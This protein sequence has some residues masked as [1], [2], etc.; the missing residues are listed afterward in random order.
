MWRLKRTNTCGQLSAADAAK[1]VRL[2]GWVANRR[3]HGELIFIDLRDRY[4]I[5]QIVFNPE[6]GAELMAR[7]HTLRPEFVC[8]VSGEVRKRP[9]GMRNK[10]IPTGEIEVLVK[11]LEILSPAKTPPFPIA[12]DVEVSPELRMKHRYLDLRREPMTRTLI[13]RH[14]LFQAFRRYFDS[15]G[16][17]EIETPF[18]TKST[19][20]GA[21]DYLVPSRIVPGSFYALP[22]SPQLF[23]QILMVSGM[24]KYFQIVRCFR[25]EDLRADRQPEFTQLDVEMSFVQQEDVLSTM[26][27]AVAQAVNEV[28]GLRLQVPFPRMTYRE[29]MDTYGSDKPDVRF[30]MKLVDI[31]GIVAGSTFN[32]FEATVKSGGNV[33]GFN[34]ENCGAWSRK[35]VDELSAFV[36]GIGGKGVAAAKVEGGKLVSGF[37]KHLGD[38]RCA[39]IVKAL[40]AKDGDLVLMAADKQDRVCEL[41]GALRLHLGEKL[42]LRKKGEFNFLWVVDFPLLEWNEEEKKLNAKHHPFTA[43]KE[44]HLAFLEERPLDVLANAYDLVLNGMEVGGGS[45]RIFQRDL[46]SRMF[47][48]LGIDEQSAQKKFG[49]LLD[50]FEYGAPPHGGIALG[51]DRWVMALTGT[52][53]I[54]DVIAFPKTQKAL[55]LMT[56]APSEV[57]EKQ[58]KELGISVD[59]QKK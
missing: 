48:L 46:Q 50:A 16:F 39:N 13:F 53:S 11:D 58:L 54:R 21:R 26:E 41:L 23:K 5:T 49:F 12:H 29:A 40:S 31:T 7:A 44:E 36:Q 59:A 1:T 15:A 42:G 34:A 6:C 17:I 37:A 32:V 18:L 9:E 10:T 3:D 52:D 28:M 24:D 35:E 22:Q 2:N 38:E 25:D 4:G 43:P 47:K 45:I 33:K 8:A 51:L 20:E 14:R 19:P 27:Q 55:C 57:A 56:E 30:G